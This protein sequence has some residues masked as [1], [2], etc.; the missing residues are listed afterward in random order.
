MS[1]PVG[2][3]VDCMKKR[4]RR[5]A[6]APVPH[7]CRTEV[8]P[9]AAPPPAAL[10]A[11]LAI[12]GER[13][14]DGT[15]R[16][17]GRWMQRRT[18]SFLVLLGLG[19]ALALR[20]EAQPAAPAAAPQ[21]PAQPIAVTGRVLDGGSGG[22]LARARVAVEGSAASVDTRADGTFQVQ[23]A[24]GATL[25]ITSADHEPQL[26]QVTGATLP[27]VVLATLAATDGDG[28]VI[29]VTGEA[30]IA[31]PGATTVTR[32][33]LRAIPGAGNDVLSSMDALPGVTSSPFG[34]PTAFNGLVIRGSA[35]ED[36]KILIDGF[37]VPYLYHNVGIRSIL[38]TESI[39]TLEYLP[40]G[41][42]V[43]Y[44][45]ASSGVVAVTTRPG[46]RQLG[47]Q[48]ELSVIDGGVLGH[49]A[50]GRG[51]ALVALR[52]STVDLVLPSVIPDDADLNLA[53]VPRYWDLQ[54]RYDVPLSARWRL[55]LSAIGADDSLEL[56][57]DDERDPDRRFFSR[58]RFL[59]GIADARWYAGQ[60]SARVAVSTLATEVVFEAGRMQ[61]FNLDRVQSGMRSELTRTLSSAAGL[62]DVVLRV[63]ADGDVSRNRLDLAVGE[64]N[65][66]GQPMAGNGDLDDIRT[67][68]QGT[69]WIPD[70][71]TWVSAAGTLGP[72]RLTTGLRVDGFARNREIAVQPRAELAVTLT[73]DAR[74]RLAAG[75]YRR[76]P[77]NQGETLDSSLDPERATQVVLGGELG[78]WRGLKLQASLY[79][80]DRSR[81]LTLIGDNKYANIGRGRTVGGELLGIWRRD[82]FSGFVS[83][84]LSR[85]TRVDR[86]G[87]STRLFDYDQ[88]HDLNIAGT[89]KL[90]RWQLGARFR[91]SSGQPYTPVMASVYESD[92]D[93]YVPIFG[94]VNSRRVDA[95]HQL[96][97]RVERSWKL[98]RVLVAAFLDVQNVYLNSAV[99]GYGYSFDYT[100]RFAFE[101][102]P[103][104]PSLGL[105]AEL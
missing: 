8:P 2:R 18:L 100:E 81:L 33:E 91:Y 104:L 6:R 102:I 24:V 94:D 34:G 13:A 92:A 17:P 98:G 73:E 90:G 47:A 48:G 40:G 52:R 71:A 46:E 79:Y 99:V 23:A 86:P 5:S 36:S 12:A 61:N 30:P 21:D 19:P 50:L 10:R 4:H 93:R 89:W 66:E 83:Y 53:T 74:L 28:E 43:S 15:G 70:A 101:S 7:R 67:R 57:A 75:A 22:P 103:I 105:R 37:E 56:F 3:S 20:A 59:R 16:A 38:P 9:A 54:L 84:S 88:P 29:A 27:D 95:N 25:I 77:E 11:D 64:S 1:K 26:V 49:G 87:A 44:G 60:W 62:R 58:T 76:P 51:Q 45:R 41:F 78:P 96:D 55:A 97:V 72:A 65:D 63:G 68:F 14:L 69:I 39:D 80:T 42:D 85:S 35:P 31:A 82:A 32:E